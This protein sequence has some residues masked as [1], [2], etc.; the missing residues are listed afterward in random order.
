MGLDWHLSRWP[1]SLRDRYELVLHGQVPGPEVAAVLA[2][3]DLAI[4]PY[5]GQPHDGRLSLRTPLALG[6]PTLTRGPRPAHLQLRAPHL[7]FDDEVDIARLA[8]VPIAARRQGA[9]DVAALEERW[10]A[11]LAD[12]L[13]GP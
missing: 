6:V 2:G 7:L 3:W 5:E 13:F 11:S 12:A 8:D 10:R 4:A 1:A 9:A